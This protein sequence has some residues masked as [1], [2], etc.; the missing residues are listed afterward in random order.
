MTMPRLHAAI[1]ERAAA[2]RRCARLAHRRSLGRQ[3]RRSARRNRRDEVR[4][5]RR[6]QR[7][8]K[9]RR[10]C[11]ADAPGDG[12][13]QPAGSS[14]DRPLRGSVAFRRRRD[15]RRPALDEARPAREFPRSRN[16]S[17]SGRDVEMA[18]LTGARLHIAHMSTAGSL[19]HTSAPRKKRGCASPAK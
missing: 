15:A 18:L 4:R 7:R 10:H 1:V 5:N 3:Q 14:G 6:R 12:L 2:A 8:R 19:E 17:A 9:T 13:L 16:R 11:P